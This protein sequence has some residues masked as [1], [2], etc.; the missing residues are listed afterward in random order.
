MTDVLGRGTF[1]VVYKATLHNQTVAVKQIDPSASQ[2]E[3]DMVVS[4]GPVP[5]NEIIQELTKQISNNVRS[6]TILSN[7]TNSS[8][9]RGNVST[10]NHSQTSIQKERDTQTVQLKPVDEVDTF[11]EFDAFDETGI[12]SFGI[13]A[14][15]RFKL[16]DDIQDILHEN[17][18]N[19]KSSSFEGDSYYLHLFRQYET[20]NFIPNQLDLL[21]E[22]N[23]REAV[24]KCLE[25]LAF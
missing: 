21:I 3:K 9:L 20:N 4:V 8:I 15:A 23:P 6:T 12:D 10:S 22:Q 16:L 13:T 2:T 25:M 1:G 19:H 18:Q 7:S 5:Y 11:D 17:C 24:A 14:A